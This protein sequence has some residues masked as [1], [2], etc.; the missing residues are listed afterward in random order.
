MK[1][2]YKTTTIS[3][4][5]AAS[6]REVVSFFGS[7][8][9]PI[10]CASRVT[11]DEAAPSWIFGGT[12]TLPPRCFP[13]DERVTYPVRWMSVVF[14]PASASNVLVSISLDTLFILSMMSL[15]VN[16]WQLNW[17]FNPF[18]AKNTREKGK[19]EK[20]SVVPFLPL[21]GR[22]EKKEKQRRSF[23]THRIRL[24]RR[25]A[26]HPIEPCG[27]RHSLDSTRAL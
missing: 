26:H 18:T 9:L 13:F 25:G 19:T 15:T 23:A 7:T 24:R 17:S 5:P 21:G 8:K 14:K 20:K 11:Y 3:R 12:L 27:A 10:S 4:T 16:L 22:E 1:S 2:I 6:W